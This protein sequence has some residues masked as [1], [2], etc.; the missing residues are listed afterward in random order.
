M[1]VFSG[2]DKNSNPLLDGASYDPMTRTWTALSTTD[3]GVARFAHSAVWLNGLM[4]VW[5]GIEL[6]PV[7]TTLNTGAIYQP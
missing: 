4:L 1:I 2:L 3:M 6:V 7:H 5:G